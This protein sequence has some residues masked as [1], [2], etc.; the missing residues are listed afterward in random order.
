MAKSLYLYRCIDK[1]SIDDIKNNNI[2][3]LIVSDR[4]PIVGVDT[5]K[6]KGKKIRNIE[7]QFNLKQFYIEQKN[8]DSFIRESEKYNIF[9]NNIVFNK[10]LTKEEDEDLREYINQKQILNILSFVEQQRYDMFR[11]ISE[12]QF[13][14]KNGNI[15]R[16]SLKESGLLSMDSNIYSELCEFLSSDE[17]ANIIGVDI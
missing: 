4:W 17:F 5:R 6:Y 13:V 7:E 14:C 11:D 2:D 10:D 16:I 3:G 12:I 15:N 1:K 9:I 8:F